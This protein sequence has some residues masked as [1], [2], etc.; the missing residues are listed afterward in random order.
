MDEQILIALNK[1][2]AALLSSPDSGTIAAKITVFGMLG[3]AIL[4]FMSQ[5]IVTKTTLRAEHKRMLDQ[6]KSDRDIMLSQLRSEYH[7]RQEE[8]WKETFRV[9][10]SELLS[11]TD[12][13]I[14]PDLNKTKVVPL[15]HRAQLIL[16]TNDVNQQ[17]INKL[18]TEL[19]LAVNGWFETQDMTSIY[20]LH[21]Q[22]LEASRQMLIIK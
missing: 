8:N 16:N 17:K 5:W 1:I 4:G 2:L 14:H 6:L 13:E 7:L 15:I 21:G 9:T 20:I 18:I 11:E 12:P 3:A 19:G 22:L 10:I